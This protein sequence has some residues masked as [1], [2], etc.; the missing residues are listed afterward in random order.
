M[1]PA[2]AEQHRRRQAGLRLYSAA[3]RW[4]K[5]ILPVGALVLI[6]LI[7]LSGQDR[8]AIIDIR[9][10][11]DIAKLGVGL[12]LDKPQF[13]GVTEDGDP[14]VV[15]ADWAL[16]D[17]S[18]PDLIDLE[19]PR[20]ELRLDDGLVLNIRSKTGRMYRKDEQL[21]LMG[22]VEVESSDGYRA[23]AE[24]LEM[25]LATKS[26]VVPVPI[27]GTGPRGDIVADRMEVSRSTPESSDLIVR[28]D[29][30]VRVRYRPATD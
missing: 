27:R 13:A 9:D 17:G 26:A 22:D 12:K 21:H 7:F 4:M 2:G 11:A 10:A 18:A 23:T 1:S 8:G 14:F 29:G 24:T 19:R 30:N 20:G 3:V 15:T 25:D 6:G 5:I 28:F 16:P